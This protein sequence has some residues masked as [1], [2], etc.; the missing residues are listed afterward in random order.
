MKASAQLPE[1]PPLVESA[2]LRAFSD[3]SPAA[4][5]KV[6]FL[7]NR[8]AMVITAGRALIRIAHAGHT[9]S[10]DANG[11]VRWNA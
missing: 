7:L 9:A 1:R 6:Q 2:D 5:R 8:G 11:R 3:G 10:I 4:T